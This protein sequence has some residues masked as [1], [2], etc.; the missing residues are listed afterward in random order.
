MIKRLRLQFVCVTMVLVAV[1][2]LTIFCMICGGV[3]TGMQ[4]EASEAMQS[5]T[6]EPWSPGGMGPDSPNPNYPC[7]LLCMD[8]FGNLSVKGHAYYDLSDK[9]LLMNILQE[10]RATGQ[11]EGV[12]AE[13]GLRF[14]KIQLW[15]ME[16]YVFTDISGQIKTMR[17]LAWSLVPIFFVAMALFFGIAWLLSKW[18]VRPIERAWEQQRQFVADASH[19]LKTPLTVILT[20]AELLQSDEYSE[21]AK[22]RFTSS[23][24]TMAVQMRGLV[25]SLLELARVDSRLSRL[26]ISSVNMSELTDM[27]VMNFEPMYFEAGRELNSSL[28]QGIFVQGSQQHLRQLL[29]ILLDNGCKYSDSGSRV[30][31]TLERVHKQCL[32]RVSSRGAVLTARQCKDIFKR[33]YRVDEA[34][35]R[36]GSYGLG[37][38][39]AQTVVQLH[40]GKIWCQ[41]KEGIN[42]FFVSLP[43]CDPEK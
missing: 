21:E 28:Q 24:H 35:S 15:K 37:L 7:F 42:T 4:M 31:L 8:P 5:A 20:N 2:L 14:R 41:S 23:I 30:E 9:A 16:E 11:D 6:L 40:R 13:R 25:E 34:R 17:N 39:I 32:L 22:H 10:A 18:M 12:L 27:A 43:A 26:Q 29:D 33:F 38:S 36:D 1:L 3:W 19:E